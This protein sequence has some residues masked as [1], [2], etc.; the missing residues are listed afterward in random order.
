[1]PVS[2]L[3]LA[4]VI[5][6]HISHMKLLL[7]P[8]LLRGGSRSRR[9]LSFPL[10]HSARKWRNQESNIVSLAGHSGPH[11]QFCHL[12]GRVRRITTFIEFKASLGYRPRSRLCRTT[13]Q[14]PVLKTRASLNNMSFLYE[15]EYYACN[16]QY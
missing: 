12:R 10:D 7:V 3:K 6:S 13:Y 4:S 1:M 2:I 11:L 8:L 5:S 9:L 15:M 14:E 16:Y